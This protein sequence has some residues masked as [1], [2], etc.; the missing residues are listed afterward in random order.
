MKTAKIILLIILTGLLYSE[1]PA[2][3]WPRNL[4]HLKKSMCLVEYYLPQPETNEIKDDTRIKQKITGILVNDKGLVMTSDIIFPANI[5]I[6]AQ[7]RFFAQIQSPPE[8]I[9]V[10]F[11]NDEKLKATL[12]GIDEDLRLAFVRINKPEDLPDPVVFD[13]GLKLRTG[14]QIYLLQHLNGQ[15]DNELITT[16]Q[17]INSLIEKPWLKWLTVATINPL[18]ACGLVAGPD[19]EPAGVVFRSDGMALGMQYEVDMSY[20]A[21]LLTELLPASLFRDL[22]KDPPKLERQVSGTGKSWLGIQMQVLKSEMADYWG[23]DTL[24][25]IIVIRVMPNSPAEQAGIRIGDIITRMGDLR[26][27]GE[28]D[29]TVDILRNHIRSLPEGPVPV[30]IWR[31]GHPMDKTV[32][33][34]SSPKSQFFAEE[35]S[36]EQLRFSVKE[37]TQD[38]I[39]QSDLDFDT[40]GVWVSRVEEAGAASLSGLM[41]DDLILSIDGHKIRNLDEFKQEMKRSL[42]SKPALIEFFIKRRDNT[43]FIYIKPDETTL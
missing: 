14:D 17:N 36:E 31:D 25:G 33:L 35:Y 1:V 22:I 30:T 32:V 40:E 19:G 23:L 3:T 15:Y 10:S 37:L 5:D 42:V 27:E 41:V 29:R 11:K 38:I 26:V 20:S 28:D 34:E 12:V 16:A 24:R 13:T 9:T 7:N 8:D 21:A 4:D 6:V 39:L 2:D 18:S 43:L